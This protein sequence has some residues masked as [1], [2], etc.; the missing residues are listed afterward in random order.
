MQTSV[1]QHR[2]NELKDPEYPVAWPHLGNPFLYVDSNHDGV[3]LVEDAV[4][5]NAQ[6]A[7]EHSI[8]FGSL[9]LLVLHLQQWCNY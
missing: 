5:Q 9:L 2:K 1:H 7:G 4:G 3:F 8:K 6:H